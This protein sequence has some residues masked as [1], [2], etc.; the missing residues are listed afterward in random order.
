MPSCTKSSKRSRFS[1]SITSSGRSRRRTSSR[2]AL[3][4]AS[5]SRSGIATSSITCRSTFR[6]R[7]ASDKRSGFYEQTGA[8]RDMV[9]THLFQILAFMAMEPPTSLE[10][11]PISEEKNKVFRSMLPIQPTDVVRGQYTGYR[12]EEGVES[13]VGN[14]DVHRVEMLDRQLALGR[15]AVLFAHRQ[16]ACRRPA[17][18]FHRV[19]RAAEEH[20]PGGLGRRRARAGSSDVRSRGRLENVAVVL[21]QASWSGHAAG[22]AE[23][24][25]RHARYRV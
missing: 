4:T 15:R 7:W 13:G 2:S 22:Q 21:W 20:V 12:A 6:K 17:D 1:G 19:S 10:P 16:A 23:P 5:S 8:F 9:V 3:R 18:H 11:S 25:V 14:G 24:A